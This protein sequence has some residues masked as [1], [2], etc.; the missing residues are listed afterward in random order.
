MP[1]IGSCA[2]PVAGSHLLS[3]HGCWSSL[4]ST[5]V[6]PHPVFGLQLSEVHLSLSSQLS[7]GSTLHFPWRQVA[8]PLVH[9]LPSAHLNP[10]GSGACMQSGPAMQV[11]A[12]QPSASEQLS[13]GL[14]G[15]GS[16]GTC[17]ST[18]TASR[19]CPASV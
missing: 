9:W 15:G 13:F 1:P 6:C 2:Q 10:S 17:P 12:V 11:S 5:G 14:P 7:G 19:A 8:T 3:S 4:Q 16:P 18:L